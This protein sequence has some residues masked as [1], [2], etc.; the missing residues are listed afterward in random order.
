MAPVKTVRATRPGAQNA[1]DAPSRKAHRSVLWT[2][3]PFLDL[4][5][6][7][8][9]PLI[10]DNAGGI[11][12]DLDGKMIIAGPP[13]VGKS[14]LGLNMIRALILGKPWLGRF[15]VPK[16]CRV[17]YIDLEMGDRSL[18]RRL[19]RLMA[20]TPKETPG[21]FWFVQLPY[22]QIEDEAGY[23]C[24]R[25]LLAA[26]KPN[27][28]IIDPMRNIHGKNE[29]KSDEMAAVLRS[30]NLL[31]DEFGCAIVLLHHA[32]K[33]DPKAGPE[34]SQDLLRGSTALSA[35]ATSI[36]ILNPDREPDRLQADFVKVRDAETPIPPLYL[37]F[38]RKTFSFEPVE[39]SDQGQKLTRSQVVAM[40]AELGGK[41]LRKP[42]IAA[43][44]ERYHVGDRTA[45]DRIRECVSAGE[46]VAEVLGPRGRTA[47]RLPSPQEAKF[48]LSG[49]LSD[50]A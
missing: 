31:M 36:L 40:V 44:Q 42:L 50:A 38:D 45:G 43:L 8:E 17:L 11:I 35:W 5:L 29:N 26:C 23:T 49:V 13:G 32:R 12:L 25:G 1:R 3:Q 34:R 14:N 39:R 47:Y 27:V 21:P 2:V 6:E 16:A 30:L 48:D 20:G 9:E 37:D 19:R 10:G 28:L 46:L 24:L 15:P 7:A 4:D 22:I 18:Q 33:G 41:A